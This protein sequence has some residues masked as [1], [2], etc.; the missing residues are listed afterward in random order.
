M[1]NAVFIPLPWG[2]GVVFLPIGARIA[3]DRRIPSEEI[4]DPDAPAGVHGMKTGWG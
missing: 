3:A 4:T 1:R 2:M